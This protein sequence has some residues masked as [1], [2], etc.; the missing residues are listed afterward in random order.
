MSFGEGGWL[1]RE[2]V[3]MQKVSNGIH[4]FENVVNVEMVG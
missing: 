4:L 1:G 3:N 2:S